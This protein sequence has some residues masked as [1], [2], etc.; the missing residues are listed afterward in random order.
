MRRIL[1]I[2]LAG[3][4]LFGC[5]GIG[6]G[7][8]TGGGTGDATAQPGLEIPG[9]TPPVEQ[10]TPS[11]AFSELGTG[12]LSKTSSIVATVTC[13]A[14]KTL[15]VMLDGAQ[16]MTAGATT[17]ATTPIELEFAPARDGTV[18][19]EVKS[20][21]ETVF[22]RDWAVKPLGNEDTGGLDTD[23]ISFKEWRAMAVDVENPIAP[24]KVKAYMKRMTFKTQPSTTITVQIR[25]DSNGN[26]GN[27]VASST[28]PFS[29][30]TQTDNWITFDFDPK[31]SLAPGRY[32][33]ILKVD[34]TEDVNLI[35][36]VAYVH[37]STIDKQ[38]P[39]ND[40]TRQMMLSVDAKT[41][42]ASETSWQPL[43]YDREYS[44]ILTSG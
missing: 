21:G 30:A 11:Y 32:W 16:V 12:T 1:L 17:N 44:L 23:G 20:D 41:G 29:V 25:T 39:G 10:C 2:L 22:S 35:S 40:Y 14:G 31:P 19:V 24:G 28:R 18:K 4:L 33:I 5:F 7:K 38:A 43:S 9:T 6:G 26:P 27:V 8:P 13:A 15:E 34:Q 42:F 37:Y 3:L 36:D